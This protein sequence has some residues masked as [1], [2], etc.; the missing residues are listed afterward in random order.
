MS[1]GVAV[2]YDESK[3]PCERQMRYCQVHAPNDLATSGL[4]QE[5]Q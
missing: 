5:R 3:V 4:L 1:K 2:L